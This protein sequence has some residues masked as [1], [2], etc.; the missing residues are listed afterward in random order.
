MIGPRYEVENSW[1]LPEI[2][3]RFG[4][5]YGQVRLSI[6]IESPCLTLIFSKLIVAVSLFEGNVV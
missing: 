5:D 3:S 4:R 2:I 6:T 1:I